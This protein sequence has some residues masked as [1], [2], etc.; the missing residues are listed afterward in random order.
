MDSCE[1]VHKNINILALT[2][3]KTMCKH[4]CSLIIKLLHELPHSFMNCQA[5]WLGAVMPNL[6]AP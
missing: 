4:N 5:M 3:T 1:H 2:K 6:E